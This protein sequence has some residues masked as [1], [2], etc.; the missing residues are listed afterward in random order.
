MCLSNVYILKDNQEKELLVKNTATVSIREDGKLVFTNLL[1]VPT[2]VDG[3]IESINLM[4]NYINVR[5]RD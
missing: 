2:I 3:Q 5:T 4:D 1:G